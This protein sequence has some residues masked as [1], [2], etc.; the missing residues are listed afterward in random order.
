M[1]PSAA[2]VSM[3]IESARRGRWLRVLRL[4]HICPVIH[5]LSLIML[6]KVA[7]YDQTCMDMVGHTVQ[8]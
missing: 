8:N 1:G 4:R 7:L 2:P 3:A 5:Y 6:Y